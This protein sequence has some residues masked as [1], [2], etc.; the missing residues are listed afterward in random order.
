[1]LCVIRPTRSR[2]RAHCS[3]KTLSSLQQPQRGEAYAEMGRGGDYINWVLQWKPV[4]KAGNLSV[5]RS[6]AAPPAAFTAGSCCRAAA[7]RAALER[8]PAEMVKRALG[9]AWGRHR[10][11]TG[12]PASPCKRWHPMGR[13]IRGPD[14]RPWVP[15]PRAPSRTAS[16]PALSITSGQYYRYQCLLRWQF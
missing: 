2:A 6:T 5:R 7:G 4:P 12:P 10:E 11:Q 15:F 9:T 1:M 16:R 13:C 8:A 3:R 14:C